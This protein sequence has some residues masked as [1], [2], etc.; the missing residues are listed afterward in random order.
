MENWML[1]QQLVGI[2]KNQGYCRQARA[3]LRMSRDITS[4][5]FSVGFLREH[6]DQSP[7]KKNGFNY[8]SVL[9]RWVLFQSHSCCLYHCHSYQDMGHV[10]HHFFLQCS[11]YIKKFSFISF[12]RYNELL[13][14][15]SAKIKSRKGESSLKLK[16]ELFEKC[17]CDGGRNESVVSHR[18]DI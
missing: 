15:Y 6:E 18:L 2:D 8:F 5:S 3:E 12:S 13:R 11:L 1:V 16:Q 14:N 17:P 4:E 9:S 7:E 10:S